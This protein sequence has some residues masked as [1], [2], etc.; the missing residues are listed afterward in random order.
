MTTP[1]L[2]R[3]LTL[4]DLTLLTIGTVI[5]S[6]IF[7]TPAGILRNVEGFPGL[8]LCVWIAGGILSLLGALTYGELTAARPQTGGLYVFI[9]D[10]F[11]PLPAFLFGWAL[12]FVISTGTVATLAVAFTTYLQELAPLT[13]WM[14]KAIAVFLIGVMA[15]VN[16]RGT[17]QS[18]DLNN[19]ATA[20]KVFAILLMSGALIYFGRGWGSAP[21]VW[22]AQM[23][24]PLVSGFGAAMISVLWAYEGWQWVTY[25]AGE[26]K[27]PQRTFPLGLFAGTLALTAIYVL[28][29]IAYV[30]ALGAAAPENNRIAAVAVATVIGPTA[31][32][33][34]TVAILISVFSAA[35]SSLITAPRVFFAMAH[36][37]IFFKSLARIHPRYQTPAFAIGASSVWAAV[38]AL[39]GTFEK[40]L[41]YVVFGGWLF[42]GL[43]AGCVFVYRRRLEAEGNTV[44]SL[45]YRVPGY[46]VTPILFI[47]S[48]VAIIANNIYADARG[49]AIGLGIIAIGLPAYWVWRRR[50]R[51][52]AR[53]V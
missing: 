41:A 33:L 18:A 29:N 2:T 42:Y 38:L 14:Q 15:A 10:C 5:G 28:A 43:A 16:I 53:G 45:P 34:L 49:S 51:E 9:R 17:R 36:D 20:T 31:A 52:A 48:A 24:A 3:T 19:W 6:G 4:R 30:S 44:A 11:G 50:A 46:P 35:N 39:S 25:S 26:T 21:A 27:D 1:T 13:M 37:G 32:K 12:F 40:L 23:S 22:P 47:L 7:L 8:A